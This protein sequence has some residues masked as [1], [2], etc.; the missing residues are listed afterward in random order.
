MG[1]LGFSAEATSP[2]GYYL[3]ELIKPVRKIFDERFSQKKYTPDLDDVFIVFICFSKEM[4]GNG[5]YKDRKYL[6]KTG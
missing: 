6:R 2:A 3:M 5:N 4:R 1:F